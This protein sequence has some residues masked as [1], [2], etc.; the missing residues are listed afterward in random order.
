MLQWLRFAFK[1]TLWPP[2]SLAMKHLG[3]PLQTVQVLLVDRERG[4]VLCLATREGDQGYTVV[5]GLR[6]FRIRW[7]RIDLSYPDDP[8]LDAWRELGEEALA[9]DS[10]AGLQTR[11]VPVQRYWDGPYRQFDCRVFRAEVD[12]TALRLKA[13]NAE[14]RPLWLRG[15]EAERVLNETLATILHDLPQAGP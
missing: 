15:R 6:R 9:P 4:L 1:K 14:G 11:L 2:L 13:E 8:A 3:R 12:S 7:S 5:Q 10:A